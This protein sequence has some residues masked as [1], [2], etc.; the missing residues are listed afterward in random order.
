MR[1][2]KNNFNSYFANVP[3]PFSTCAVQVKLFILVL[4][5]STV[6]QQFVLL[7]KGKLLDISTWWNIATCV[8]I[9]VKALN[10][11]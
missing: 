4:L 3:L 6:E 2:I 5:R 8:D 9:L 7:L 10:W 11:L 1:K